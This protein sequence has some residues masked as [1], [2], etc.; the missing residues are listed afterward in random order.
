M[1]K[2]KIFALMLPF[3]CAAN[4][5]FALE[6]RT[7]YS[8]TGESVFKI[9]FFDVG[10]GAFMSN[11]P[12]PLQSTWNLDRLQKEKITNAVSYW[13][14]LIKPDPDT[15]PA[16]INVGTF[17]DVNAAGTSD[18][19]T[20]PDSFFSIT[21][22]QAAL[23]GVGDE[24]RTF[25]S[26]AQFVMGKMN[27]DTVPY[28]P[29]QQP[30]HDGPADLVGTAFHELAHGLGVLNFVWEANGPATPHFESF[31][32]SLG[33][34]LRD[35]NGNP[36]RPGQ[37][38]L[39]SLCNNPYDPD[40]FDA[41]KDQAYFYGENVS[42]V[43]GDAMPG[44]PVRMLAY[45]FTGESRLDNNYMSHFELK[46]SMMSHQFYR[47]Y[48]TFME[49]ELAVLQDFG[50]DIDRR[51]FFGSSV[52][53]NDQY[54]ENN[55][56][57]FKRNREGTA[58]LPGQYNTATLGLGL[59]VYGDRNTIVQ[60]ADLLSEGAGG[61]GIR[62]DG[63]AN[64]IIIPE[65][66]RVHADG[67]NGR[68]VMFSYG[69]DHN[70][71]LRGDVQALG[72][73]GIGA[74][75]DFGNHLLGNDSEYRGSYIF[76]S[77]D[78]PYPIL[79]ELNGALVN[80]FDITG[81]IAGKAHA[82]YISRNALVNNINV[83]QGAQIQGNIRSDYAQVDA[84]GNPRLTQISFGQLADASGRATGMPD[85]GFRWRY[86]GN[87]QGLDNIVLAPMGGITVLN[88]Q[89]EIY[90]V[91]IGPEATLGGNSRYVLKPGSSFVNDGILSPGNS[92]GRIDIVGDYKQAGSGILL[93]ETN[94][95]QEHDVLAVNGQAEL[96]GMLFLVPQEREWYGQNWRLRSS[97]LIQAGSIDGDFKGLF[98]GLNSPTLS[99]STKAL[100]GNS[101]FEVRI[102][103][104]EN[105]YSRYAA[106]DNATGA[107]RA[108][109]KLASDANA[110]TRSLLT[111]LD[112]SANDGSVITKA[113]NQL[114]PSAYSAMFAS[115]LSREQ[116][117]GGI[118]S[119]RASRYYSGEARFDG[120]TGFA[121]PFGGGVWQDERGSMVG[122]SSSN[123]GVLFGAEKYSENNPAWVFGAYGAVSGQSVDV[124]DP[125]K[126]KGTST[127]FNLG[128]HV[129]FAPDEKA[130]LYA[131]GQVQLGVEDAKL[132]RYINFDGYSAK[133]TAD[134]T[135]WS[136]SLTAG[137]G[138]RWAL[139][140]TVSAGPL[141]SLAYTH[142][143]RPDLTESG[144][145]ATRLDISSS[146]F[147]SLVSRMGFS[148]G[149]DLPLK[150]EADLRA[151]LQVSWDH[152]WQDRD[153]ILDVH[154]DGYPQA[155]FSN[156]NQVRGRDA[157]GL[158]AGLVYQARQNL[159]IGANISSQF[160]RTGQNSVAGN[161][162]VNW[163]F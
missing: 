34:G 140:E 28:I 25:D 99:V 163:Q 65:G 142:L 41:R 36:A 72:D 77:G 132:K 152:E 135:G 30:R 111:T 91:K 10:D 129:R 29:S 44:V 123:Y 38:I 20:K 109:Y 39:C 78:K 22:L 97:D 63:Q 64:H 85:V 75:F 3:V 8:P 146:R 56:G 58:Y 4:S 113:L 86:D 160:F 49:A 144:P 118:V 83:M 158:Q 50:Y 155:G 11:W 143:S 133:H 69:K 150:N 9:R 157:L 71:T 88:G 84:D 23:L 102:A 121:T 55:N 139:S 127:A 7:I 108:L 24:W 43:L 134:W 149:V 53:G 54:L 119:S 105:A 117:V 96:D 61:A 51:N 52:Y 79:A 156:R 67:L 106:N 48:T 126:A 148:V 1:K 154:F 81:R 12:E 2:L 46:N 59:H 14:E 124:D 26:H 45:K 13:A 145:L 161:V 17:E 35:D 21:Q 112:F 125:Y 130:G 73:L 159:S 16:V 107:G 162:S 136:G 131:F 27:F 19:L 94:G 5:S 57:Y 80:S 104:Q 47:N 32:G 128:S 18:P 110:D 33:Q 76:S 93:M 147:N 87:I 100:G 42:E 66:T 82:I 70:L 138:Y 122:Y 151:D 90:G 74:S 95:A 98:V 31:L 116:Q 68:G 141:V 114:T 37:A 120:W 40:A 60:Q 103:R 6:E 89:H 92:I 62:V 101:G 153:S 15:L 137:G 115:S